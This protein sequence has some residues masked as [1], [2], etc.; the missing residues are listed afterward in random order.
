MAPM[1][2][3]S[4]QLARMGDL[5]AGD[6]S[7]V[8]GLNGRQGGSPPV[9]S[10]EL[11]FEGFA[12]AVDM[13]HTPHIANLQ[14]FLG[15]RSGQ[16]DPIVFSDHDEGSLPSRIG[17]DQARRLRTSIDDPDGPGHPVAALLSLRRYSSINNIFLAM[18][19]LD[20]LHDFPRLGD[21]V[22]SAGQQF[23]ILAREA[24]RLE[25]LR[26]AAIVWM[27]GVKEVLQQLVSFDDGE[28]GVSK[29]HDRALCHVADRRSR[30][31]ATVYGFETG[32]SGGSAPLMSLESH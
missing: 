8:G 6:G 10:G 31:T 20:Q 4:R 14:A 15:D 12:V 19:R 25:E 3:T 24:E 30:G 17:R 27:R 26:L 7:D 9:E 23:R 28:V 11:H 22:E 16:D 32:R 1:E 18:R 29:L 21:G 5:A 13:N 2:S